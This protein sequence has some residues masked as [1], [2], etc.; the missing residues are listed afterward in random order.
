MHR[1]LSAGASGLEHVDRES[2]G[3]RG[4][5]R[6]RVTDPAPISALPP[7]PDVLHDVLGFRHAA[8]HAIG[9]AKQP[10]PGTQKCSNAIVGGFRTGA[11]PL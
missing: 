1:A 11:R 6:R 3:R 7:N 5:E 2:R 4:E 8:Q 10:R 9:D